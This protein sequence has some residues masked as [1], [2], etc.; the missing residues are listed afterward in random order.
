[1]PSAQLPIHTWNDSLYA[2]IVYL[3][4]FDFAPTL[5]DLQKWLLRPQ[6]FS[7]MPSL[8]E[9]EAMLAKDE[10]IICVEGVCVLR[11]RE[12]LI[13][14]RKQK[15]NYTDAKWQH[16][17]P[18]IRLLSFMPFVRGIWLCNSMGWNNARR[19]SDIDLVIIAEDRHVW[20]ARF[21]TAALMK[22]LRQRP[23]EQH[24]AK[25]LCLSMYISNTHLNI[26]DSR[27]SPTSIGGDIYFDFWCT[28]LY[29]VIDRDDVYKRFCTENQWLS[30]TFADIA[31]TEPVPHRQLNWK[32]WQK[33]LQHVFELIAWPFEKILKYWQFRIMPQ[34]LRDLANQDTRVRLNDSVLKFHTHDTRQ[35]IH[36][37]F[38][39]RLG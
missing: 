26:E 34:A 4:L 8:S 16:A 38:V 2:T 35:E 18:F 37:R 30:N 28:Q 23:G 20:T 1:M 19:L 14:V 5:L 39:E 13:E 29:P 27:L 32:S 7:A 11:G 9:M 21:F 33:N 31:W 36:Q 15:Y 17:K 22:L 6:Q 3:D 25:A 12:S 24:A 10:R